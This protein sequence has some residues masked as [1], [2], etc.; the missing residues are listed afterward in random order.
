RSR[1]DSAISSDSPPPG[2][3]AR[4]P[5]SLHAPPALTIRSVSVFADM[6]L[7]FRHAYTACRTLPPAA[8]L[9]QGHLET[10]GSDGSKGFGWGKAGGA[11]RGRSPA[12]APMRM[13][14]ARPPPQA[15]AG[16]T[17]VQCLTW[18]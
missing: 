11:D 14:A 18:A 17:A 6:T 8:G 9:S 3:C 10:V 7:L 13:A 15:V 2:R 16:T 12:I 5:G 1:S 4:P